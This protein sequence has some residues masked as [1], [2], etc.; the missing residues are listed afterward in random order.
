MEPF[1]GKASIKSQ[2]HVQK[3]QL[4]MANHHLPGFQITGINKE[5]KKSLVSTV[6]FV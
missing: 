3:T 2:D 5:L 4:T 6:L 1:E